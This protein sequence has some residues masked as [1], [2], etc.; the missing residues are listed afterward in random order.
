M[1]MIYR[2]CQNKNPIKYYMCTGSGEGEF[3]SDKM[4]TPAVVNGKGY[5][6]SGQAKAAESFC[7]MQ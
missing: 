1:I 5:L 6:P 2:N 3:F 7:G 4:N